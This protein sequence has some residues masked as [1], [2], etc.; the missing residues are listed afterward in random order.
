MSSL[1]YM[2]LRGY[3]YDD[4]V[5]ELVGLPHLTTLCLLDT[6]VTSGCLS[7]LKKMPSLK[8]MYTNHLANELQSFSMELSDMHVLWHRLMK[9]PWAKTPHF[10]LSCKHVN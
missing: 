7:H 4:G 10:V 9:I 3:A 6:Q 5:E 1:R 8:G 2:S